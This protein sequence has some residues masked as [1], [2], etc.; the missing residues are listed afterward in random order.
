MCT[1]VQAN[2]KLLFNANANAFKKL[3]YSDFSKVSSIG[4]MCIRVCC[5]ELIIS[6]ILNFN[7]VPKMCCVLWGGGGGTR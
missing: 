4:W 5:F 6:I 3:G 1:G 7:K 2:K